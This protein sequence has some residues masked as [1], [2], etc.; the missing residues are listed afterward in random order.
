MRYRDSA[1]FGKRQ[2]Y[3]AISSLLSKGFDVYVT[4]VDD[5]QIDC[6]IRKTINKK[7]VYIDIQIKARSKKCKPYDAGR[8]AAMTIKNPRRNYFFVFYSEQVD[9]YWVIPSLELVKIASR[10]KKGKNKGKYHVNLTGYSKKRDMV[11]PNE[12]YKRYKDAFHLLDNAF[13]EL[14]KN[15]KEDLGHTK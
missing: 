7:P 11:Y 2:E 12:K 6:I 3:V 10:N 15:E 14:A 8:F 5:Q 9:V 1:S 4:L 13:K